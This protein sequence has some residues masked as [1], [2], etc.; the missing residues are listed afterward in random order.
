MKW[1]SEL[2]TQFEMKYFEIIDSE[3]LNETMILENT[4]LK[5]ALKFT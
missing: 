2:Q 1:L 3:K 4:F 5:V